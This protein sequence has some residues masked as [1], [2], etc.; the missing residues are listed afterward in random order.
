LT[1][2][3]SKEGETR[4]T[5]EKVGRGTR[6]TRTPAEVHAEGSHA[7]RE[8]II[9]RTPAE[10]VWSGISRRWQAQTRLTK[11]A[12]VASILGLVIGVVALLLQTRSEGKSPSTN[13]PIAIS[14]GNNNPVFYG[15]N[16]TFNSIT[17]PAAPSVTAGPASK[18]Y[19]FVGEQA[20]RD[21]LDFALST[22]G[23]VANAIAILKE[24]PHSSAREEECQRVFQYA[25][26][27]SRREDANAVA[28][29]CFEGQH[30][31]EALE[32][33]STIHTLEK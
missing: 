22:E 29:E 31:V 12:E 30:L 24:F 23:S 9:A 8:R 10:M 11:W 14:H 26:K 21:D 19:V 2:Q 25:I 32:E 17:T 33:V 7:G 3:R 1:G 13:S 15:G 20:A 5:G 4:N 18:I 27:H 16:N 6:A 28:Q